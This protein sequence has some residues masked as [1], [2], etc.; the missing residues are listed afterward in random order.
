MASA[1]GFVFLGT[2]D[3]EQLGDA[4]P[5]SILSFE[6]GA[7]GGRCV[8]DPSSDPR[9]RRHSTQLP[10]EPEAIAWS[11]VSASSGVVCAAPHTQLVAISLGRVTQ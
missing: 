2:E 11:L 1:T 10:S 9:R 5:K 7:D 8:T 6:V 3:Y 4:Y